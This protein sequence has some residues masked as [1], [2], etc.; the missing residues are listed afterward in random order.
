MIADLAPAASLPEIRPASQPAAQMPPESAD[1]LP[2]A[3][4]PPAKDAV[5][6]PTQ[7]QLKTRRVPSKRNR[8]IYRQHVLLNRSQRDVAAEF[9]LTQPRVTAICKQVKAWLRKGQAEL[10]HMSEEERYNLV[11]N[12]AVG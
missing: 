10:D 1:T 2:G 12:E 8:E 4:L 3:G 11:T 5:V 9:D 7:E 6:L